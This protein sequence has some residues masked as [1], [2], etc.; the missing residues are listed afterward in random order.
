MLPEGTAI[1]EFS[2]GKNFPGK[3]IILNRKETTITE[4]AN[5]NDPSA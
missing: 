1:S 5:S 3:F 4:K 2:Q